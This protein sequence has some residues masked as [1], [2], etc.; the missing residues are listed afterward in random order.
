MKLS[1][2]VIKAAQGMLGI[3]TF[4][5]LVS[6]SSRV[7]K[8][9]IHCRDRFGTAAELDC[10]VCLTYCL[11]GLI[12]LLKDQCRQSAQ[13]KT[14]G[15]AQAHAH[16]D[17]ECIAC[18][19]HKRCLAVRSEAPYKR[20][21]VQQPNILHLKSGLLCCVHELTQDKLPS[22]RSRVTLL[23]VHV[24]ASLAAFRLLKV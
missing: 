21:L 24:R 18:T 4:S 14:A 23:D 10:S 13:A 16:K 5:V 17:S 20:I 8:N 19:P 2:V 6:Q 9:A 7:S 3:A 1:W 15:V 22:C 12:L 11:S